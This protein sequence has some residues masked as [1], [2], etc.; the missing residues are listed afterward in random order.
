MKELVTD[1]HVYVGMPPLYKVSSR[2]NVRYAYDDEELKRIITETG[3]AAYQLQRYKG[4]GEMNPEQL[5]ETTMNPKNRS[6]TRVGIEDAADA[7]KIVSILMGDA[8]EPRKRYIYE[9]AD[10]NKT[11]LFETLK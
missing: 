9:Y 6:L 8:V 5:W 3:K 10:F 2:G 1:G 4:L 7:E 11:T